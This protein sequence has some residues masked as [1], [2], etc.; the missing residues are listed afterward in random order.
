M[1]RIIDLHGGELLRLDA[2]AGAQVRVLFGTIWLT[3]PGRLDDVFA[4]GGDEVVLHR[5]GRV[6]LEAQRFARVIV[7]AARPQS[8]LA[9]VIARLRAGVGRLLPVPAFTAT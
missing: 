4:A 5:G 8:K 2:A 1:A 9:D 3:E 7:P 6:L